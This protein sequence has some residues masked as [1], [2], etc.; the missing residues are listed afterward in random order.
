VKPCC[1]CGQP[2]TGAGFGYPA[3]NPCRPVYRTCFTSVDE[4]IRHCVPAL[5]AVDVERCLNHERSK[6]NRRALILALER[7]ARRLAKQMNATPVAAPAP[8][9]SYDLIAHLERQ[10]RFSE[11]AFGPGKRTAGVLAHIRKELGEI[12]SN[13]DD[14]MEWVDV[15]LLA[16]D[17]A[18]RRGATSEQIACALLVKL[19]ANEKRQWPD[20]RNT[21]EDQPIEHVRKSGGAE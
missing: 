18:W 16:M 9:T 5:N 20:W 1:V 2:F 4:A 6:S 7:R 15:I 11:K 17:G 13:P 8:V 12:E 10:R 21:P 19:E 14:L 3:C